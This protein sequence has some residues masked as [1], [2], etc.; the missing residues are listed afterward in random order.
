MS[1]GADQ[2]SASRIELASGVFAP[3]SAVRVQYSRSGGPG[4]QNV[5]K[6][7]TRVQL[8]LAVRARCAGLRS[9]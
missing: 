9:A 4:G 8:W 1:D 7:N 2:L 5:N 3:A 6:V